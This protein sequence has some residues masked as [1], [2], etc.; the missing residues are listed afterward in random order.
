[1]TLFKSPRVLRIQRAANAAQKPKGAVP[2]IFLNI[3]GTVKQKNVKTISGPT[4]VMIKFF[5]T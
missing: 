2:K 5:S 4:E 3:S 1:M